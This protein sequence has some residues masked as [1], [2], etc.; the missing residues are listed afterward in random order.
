M[1][2]DMDTAIR[3][4]RVN[5]REQ[6]VAPLMSG[7]LR[8]ITRLNSRGYN[9]GDYIRFSVLPMQSSDIDF[10]VTTAAERKSFEA[11]FFKVTF[12]MYSKG[13]KEGY[14]TLSIERVTD[15][16]LLDRLQYELNRVEKSKPKTAD[17]LDAY[18]DLFE[19]AFPQGYDAQYVKRH[20]QVSLDSIADT[21][22]DAASVPDNPQ[23]Y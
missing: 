13:L 18:A 3:L 9:S 4:H 1:A 8:A 2:N 5:M 19:T 7:S 12:A 17:P 15:P 23:R 6:F 20:A 10:S 14:V 22:N 11:S 16:K 21:A